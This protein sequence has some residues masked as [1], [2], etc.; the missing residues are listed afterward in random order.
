MS[1]TQ[2]ETQP[3]L[4]V[5]GASNVDPAQVTL[6]T[7]APLDNIQA[8]ANTSGTIPISVTSPVHG[9]DVQSLDQATDQS[10]T[11]EAVLSE[12]FGVN[13]YIPSRI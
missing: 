8:S 12:E 4:V 3:G 2:A 10:E 6:V 7:D 5:S 11:W 1:T 13:T 9:A